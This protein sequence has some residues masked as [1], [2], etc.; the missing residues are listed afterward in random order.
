VPVAKSAINLSAVDLNL[1][2]VF[3]ALMQE[4]NVTKAARRLSLSQPAVSHALGRLRHMLRD[5]LFVRSPKGMVPT[6]RAEQ[7]AGPVRHA[8]EGLH[9]ALEE[10]EFDPARATRSFRIAVDNYSAIVLTAPLA[11]RIARLAPNITLEFQPSGTLDLADLFDR[12]LLDLALGFFMQPPERFGHR[13]LLADGLVV[14]MRKDHPA[15]SSRRLTP[16]KFASL[17]H[18]E[19]SSTR[20]TLAFVEN[21]LKRNKLTRRIAA[22]APLLSA[23]SILVS[24]DSITVLPGRIAQAL[25]RFYPVV[26]R[27]L[28]FTS[29]PVETEMLWPRWLDSVPAHRWLRQLVELTAQARDH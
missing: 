26:S 24:S 28:P 29:P 20:Y 12:G 13:K 16:E 22:R 2:V 3:D 19:V 18:L 10:E 5:E 6:P 4:R 7:L 21:A 14:L 17:D 9:R 27:D 15:A 25:M 1:L 11:A 8:I 23:G